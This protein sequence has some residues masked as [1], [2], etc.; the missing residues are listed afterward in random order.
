MCQQIGELYLAHY[1]KQPEPEKKTAAAEKKP[2][3]TVKISPKK[4]KT[5][6]GTYWLE[7]SKLLRKIV[8]EGNKL[9]YVRSETNRTELAPISKSEFIMKGIGVH[10]TVGF[11]D[12]TKD[13]YDTI[14]VT[15]ANQP[16]LKGKWIEPFKPT[17]KLLEE[18]TGRYFSDELNVHYDLV[19]EKDQLFLKSRNAEDKP[20]KGLMKDYFTYYDGFFKFEFQRDEQGVVTGFKVS[21]N[22]VLN[23]QF[24]KVN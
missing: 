11:S 4:L 20:F 3:K 23:L 18:Y 15:V 24:K 8:L 12:R 10:V 7:S 6:T 16:P 9:Y 2:A 5:F 1:L 19:L 13:R 14:I 17:K 22:R 21:S